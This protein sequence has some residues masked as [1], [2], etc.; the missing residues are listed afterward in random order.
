MRRFAS[1][2]MLFATV[3]TAACCS[4][5]KTGSTQQIRTTSRPDAQGYIH[6]WLL[7]DPIALDNAL[8]HVEEVEKPMFAR[9]YFKGHLTAN[10]AKSD[11]AIINGKEHR[12]REF[13]V[14]ETDYQ[15]DL[16]AFTA[17][18]NTIS[19]S[20]MFMGVA[21]VLAEQ[22]IPNVKLAIGSDDSSLWWV[23]GAEVIRVYESR[24][25]VEDNDVSKPLTLKK[26]VN[27][28][29]FA[30]IQGDGP[31]G[32]CARFI[33]AA[34]KPVTGIQVLSGEMRVPRNLAGN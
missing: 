4:H 2:F 1:V 33:D 22:D 15:L 10:P 30:V 18:H 26:G 14:P 7:L 25:V 8:E 28:V 9:E 27:V 23:N 20:C 21:Y 12:W 34:D 29:R 17:E 24:G 13:S 11:W 16:A 19:E 31:T 32:A 6:H 5:V 3:A